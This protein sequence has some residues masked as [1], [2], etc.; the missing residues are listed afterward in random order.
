MHSLITEIAYDDEIS[1]DVAY[2]SVAPENDSSIQMELNG[3]IL[4]LKIF[5]DSIT[6]IRAIFNSYMRWLI[7]LYELEEVLKHDEINN[8]R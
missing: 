3:N 2:K 1:A 7:S 4:V 6:R 8:R 5:N